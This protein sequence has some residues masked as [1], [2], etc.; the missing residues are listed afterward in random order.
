M[1][2][3]TSLVARIGDRPAEWLKG[4]SLLVTVV[5]F[6]FLW[7]APLD[8]TSVF[9][10]RAA[11]IPVLFG[12]WVLPFAWIAKRADRS[13]HPL[14]LYVFLVAALATALNVHFNDV[15]TFDSAKPRDGRQLD[16]PTAVGLWRTANGC[17]VP[18]NSQ[19]D[20]TLHSCPPALIIA[21]E[22][23][24]SR[25]AY[26]TA[27]IVGE[28]LDDFNL[29][30]LANNPTA[31]A[32]NPARRIFAMSGVSGGALGVAAIK[33]ALLDSAGTA[34]CHKTKSWRQCLQDLVSGDYLSPVFV[35]VGLRDQFAP[36]GVVRDDRAALLEMS[37]ER[38]YLETIDSKPFDCD[39]PRDQRGLCRAFGYPENEQRWTPLLFLNGTS[40]ETGRRIIA[41]EVSSTWSDP[42]TPTKTD[43]PLYQWAYDLFEMLSKPCVAVKNGACGQGSPNS[44]PDLRLSTAALI[45]ARFPVISPAGT[46]PMRDGV[47][48]D[49]VVDGGYFE[50]SGLS[51]ALDVAS[52]IQQLGLTPVILSIANE[53]EPE[54]RRGDS[55]D[56]PV[57]T[58][59]PIAGPQISQ[60][61]TANAWARLFATAYAPAI[62]LYATRSGHA[63]EA[64]SLLA[65]SLQQWDAPPGLTQ[66]DKRA[67]RYADFFPLKVF[68]DGSSCEKPAKVDEKAQSFEMPSLSMS[69]WL[70]TAVRNALDAQRCNAK[71]VDQLNLL[72]ARLNCEGHPPLDDV[73]YT[74]ECGKDRGR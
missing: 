53:P 50:N 42:K 51:T 39:G 37:W 13:G 40:A 33:A 70:S 20:T 44:A 32:G 24:A 35:G 48:G 14:L 60:P 38:R 58:V 2:K 4:I 62:T 69:W 55:S 6:V 17:P 30:Y 57:T 34:P 63:D 15:R 67:D 11:L 36:P 18:S 56:D 5:I 72:E 22:G 71:N 64:G 7:A 46:V 3:R 28:M 43:L 65:K 9:F 21:A 29:T 31:Q 10:A 19:E 41:S 25:A 59:R 16:L 47:H 45:S 27:T 68:A 12:S 8:A 23:G 26:F 49:S 1:V 54:A 61:L 52:S 73:Q 66:G 74:L